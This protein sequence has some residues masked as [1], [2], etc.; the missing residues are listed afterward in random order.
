M[1]PVMVRGEDAQDL[2]DQVLR[3][4]RLNGQAD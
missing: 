1:P 2:A 4:E 3:W